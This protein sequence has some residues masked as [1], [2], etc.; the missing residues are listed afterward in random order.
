MS[1]INKSFKMGSFEGKTREIINRNQEH[2]HK[3]KKR[4]KKIGTT[5]FISTKKSN[6]VHSRKNRRLKTNN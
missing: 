6:A 4:K 2:H 5:K 1:N 3:I